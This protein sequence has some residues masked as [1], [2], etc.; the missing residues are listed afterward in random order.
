M[1]NNLHSFLTWFFSHY[2]C[3]VLLKDRVKPFKDWVIGKANLIYKKQAALLHRF[4][5][6]TVVPL[7]HTTQIIAQLFDLCCQ[8][9]QLLVLLLSYELQKHLGLCF[10]RRKFIEFL[11]TFSEDA[12]GRLKHFWQLVL[13]LLQIPACSHASNE[14]WSFSVLVTVDRE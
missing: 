6:D 12:L 5:Q 7:K 9:F 4:N 1:G 11:S 14:I 2:K 13:G 3:P 8:V 10:K